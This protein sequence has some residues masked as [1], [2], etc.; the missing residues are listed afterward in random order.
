MPKSAPAAGHSLAASLQ[1]LLKARKAELTVGEMVGRIESGDGPGPVLFVLT[2]PVLLPLP[3][4]VSMLLALPLLMVA[5][6]IVLGRSKLWMPAA[7]SRH[8][9][10]REALAKLL[11]R[12]L[13]PLRRFERLVRPRLGF[14]T[15]DLGARLVGLA[16]TLIAVVLVLPIPFA[17]FVPAV[18]LTMF[19]LGLARRDG[20]MVLA[21]YGLMA[22]AVVVVILGVH[23]AAFG[24][25]RLRAL[26]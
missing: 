20:L 1:P 14:L 25:A 4:G 9:I 15:G 23:G 10:K 13:P 7:L 6:Q 16:C 12:I 22:L 18:A 2:L 24:V 5:P 19:A 17:N 26:F 21:G 11:H 3:P 8:A